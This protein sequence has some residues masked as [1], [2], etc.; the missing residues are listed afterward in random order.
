MT[1]FNSV[2]RVSVIFR[3]TN[4][5][6]LELFFSPGFRLFYENQVDMIRKG[7]F[8]FYSGIG[9]NMDSEESALQQI[10][11]MQKDRIKELEDAMSG[12]GNIKNDAGSNENNDESNEEKEIKEKIKNEKQQEIE[13][14]EAKEK[15]ER[16]S[17]EEDMNKLTDENILLSQKI[18]DYEG[19]LKII[20]TKNSES[21]STISHLTQMLTEAE[22]K[23]NL[24][25]SEKNTINDLLSDRI[26]DLDSMVRSESVIVCETELQRKRAESAESQGTCITLFSYFTLFP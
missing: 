4:N 6:A 20:E 16:K 8:D 25:Q 21:E 22:E 14:N 3:G 18:T 17:L 9:K 26:L 12:I 11:L 24:L 2:L 23:N 15:N 7:I 13:D 1:D 5:L 19:T 10:L